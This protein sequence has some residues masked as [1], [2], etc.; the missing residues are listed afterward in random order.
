M[1]P[2]V[3]KEKMILPWSLEIASKSMQIIQS[4][5]ADSHYHLSSIY[6]HLTSIS[7][8]SQEHLTSISRVSHEH[9]TSI[10]SWASHQHLKRSVSR[11]SQE[12]PTSISVAS[13]EF[14]FC[15]SWNILQV[16]YQHLCTSLYCA[17]R[18]KIVGRLDNWSI[19]IWSL[20]FAVFLCQNNRRHNPAFAAKK[21]EDLT[22][23]LSMMDLV[24]EFWWIWESSPLCF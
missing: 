19:M 16:S 6:E 22:Q 1:C 7:P 15:I 11:A 20:K 3:G 18:A 12:P 24:L 14:V 9:L 10:S 21:A 23:T 5:R 4:I 13:Y 17:L 8:V 2:K